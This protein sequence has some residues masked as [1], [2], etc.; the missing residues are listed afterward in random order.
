MLS[1]LLLAALLVAPLA[2]SEVEGQAQPPGEPPKGLMPNLGRPTRPDDK[3]PPLDFEKYFLGRWTFEA[4][5]PDSAR[6]WR[7]VG[8]YVTY[9]KLAEGFYE[10]IVEG[11]GE[12]GAFKI[13]ESIAYD[14]EAQ[15]AFRH[16]SDSRGYAYVQKARCGR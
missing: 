15:M 16:V 7:R 11:K 9:R 8:R 5:A 13:V 6:P 3:V 10:A 14:V 12:T 1:R 2:L 4:D